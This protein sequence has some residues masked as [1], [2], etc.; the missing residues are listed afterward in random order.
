MIV[1]GFLSFPGFSP[2]IN[3]EAR[4]GLSGQIGWFFEWNLRL[5]LEA[6]IF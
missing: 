2:P 3:T 5:G 6:Q 4:L 1:N